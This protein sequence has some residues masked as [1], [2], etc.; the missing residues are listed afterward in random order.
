L[1]PPSMSQYAQSIPPSS[2]S[3]FG[4][5]IPPPAYSFHSQSIPP[6]SSFP[7]SQGAPSFSSI[8][9]SKGRDSVGGMA[10]SL[11]K[12]E[13]RDIAFAKKTVSKSQIQ[14]AKT[15]FPSMLPKSG[16]VS[17]LFDS[18]KRRTTR[19]KIASKRGEKRQKHPQ[20]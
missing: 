6:A 18:R 15:S 12:Q 1:P 3:Q 9:A 17:P 10:M 19:P 2:L 20:R 8:L 7:L 13:E 14:K 16:S 4:Q 11:N 5:S